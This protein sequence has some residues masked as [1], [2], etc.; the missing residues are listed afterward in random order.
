M[1]THQ[2]KAGLLKFT[3]RSTLKSLIRAKAGQLTVREA[4]EFMSQK[5][6]QLWVTAIGCAILTAF[7]GLVLSAWLI[8]FAPV[9]LVGV[10]YQAMLN[11]KRWLTL[12]PPERDADFVEVLW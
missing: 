9:M 11:R 5:G 1:S 3:E 10:P 2:I 8:L 12:L 6:L 7:I 4:R